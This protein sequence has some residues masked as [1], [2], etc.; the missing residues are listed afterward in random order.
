[1]AK[2]KF[3]TFFFKKPI[4]PGFLGRKKEKKTTEYEKGYVLFIL[5]FL[6]RIKPASIRTNVK[7]FLL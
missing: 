2:T 3:I 6:N 1:M 7:L 4:S 5:L